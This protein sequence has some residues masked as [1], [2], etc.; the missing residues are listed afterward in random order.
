MV[1]GPR[2]SIGAKVL[3][4]EGSRGTEDAGIIGNGVVIARAGAEDA[5]I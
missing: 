2:E 5:G 3:G 1:L 4:A